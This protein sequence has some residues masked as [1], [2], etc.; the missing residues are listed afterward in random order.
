MVAQK[1]AVTYSWPANESRRAA[2]QVA[3]LKVDDKV[4]AHIEETGLHFEM[5]VEETLAE[6]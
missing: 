1:K 5:E 2:A 3:S 6:K 4:L